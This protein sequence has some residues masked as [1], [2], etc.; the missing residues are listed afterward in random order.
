MTHTIALPK[1]TNSEMRAD[2]KGSTRKENASNSWI[3]D[4]D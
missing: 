4:K 1:N 3:T 2:I